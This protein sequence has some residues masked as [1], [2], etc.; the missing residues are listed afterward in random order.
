MTK[1]PNL[2]QNT[3]RIIEK[4]QFM[5]LYHIHDG[6]RRHRTHIRETVGYLWSV[7]ILCSRPYFVYGRVCRIRTSV[8]HDAVGIGPC[9]PG[10]WCWS[11]AE[12]A[13]SHH[14]RYLHSLRDRWMGV[15]GGVFGLAS[16]IGLTLGGWITDTL[17]W[18]WVFDINLPIAAVALVMVLI[19]LPTVRA[20][21]RVRLDWTGISHGSDRWDARHVFRG[22]VACGSR[23]YWDILLTRGT[24]EIS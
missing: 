10:P 12:H 16:I 15:I 9:R 11:D 17:G 1:E 21:H 2:L 23:L 8:Y 5:G 18:R 6:V 14:R 4:K 13:A 20:D 22:L 24:L 3:N 7:T 19:S